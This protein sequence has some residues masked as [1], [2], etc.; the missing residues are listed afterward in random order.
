MVKLIV[1]M[2]WIVCSFTTMMVI[3]GC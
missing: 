3:S 1:F 2:V